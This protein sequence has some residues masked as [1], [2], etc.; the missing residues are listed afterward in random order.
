MSDSYPVLPRHPDLL[1]A[2]QS[3]LLVVDVQEKLLAVMPE[4]ELLI[5]RCDRL[6]TVAGALDVPVFATEQYPK[7]LGSTA[8]PLREKLGEIP[9]KLRFSCAECLAWPTAAEDDF[10]RDQ[11]VVCGME[12]HVCV[13]Q[14]VFDL[15][16]SG[17]RVF[18]VVDAVRSRFAEDREIAL[19][20]MESA[21]ATL[22]TSESVLFEWC[23]EAG[24]E[25]FKEVS[26]LLKGG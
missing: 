18:V 6:L 15:L 20:R 24:T 25:E 14:T 9:E 3:R 1:S 17:Y 2:S 5:A 26:R 13:L 21:G 22:V 12:T 4:R 16:A 7:G 11:V 10:G 23:E 8:A 19:R